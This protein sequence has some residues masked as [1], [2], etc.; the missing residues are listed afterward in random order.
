[1]LVTRGL[2][3]VLCDLA[4]LGFNARWGII[5]ADDIGAN[6][7]R[8]RIWIVA[9][10]G[11]HSNCNCKSDGSKHEKKQLLADTYSNDGRHR[12][13]TEP[14]ERNSRME[15][16]CCS[17]RQFDKRSYENVADPIEQRS[18]GRLPGRSDSQRQSESG[19]I[20]CSSS[21]HGQQRKNW[22][23]AEPN[24]GRVVNGMAARSHRLKAIGNGQ[25]PEVVRVA[26]QIL[27]K[28]L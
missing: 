19:H 13:C 14:Q 16:G 21:I 3:T 10:N 26:W 24:V 7:K 27:S 11:S 15:F 25:V 22:W 12:R 17:Q 5:G 6:H 8:K 9:R 4:K 28:D 23:S 1:M 18:Q 2:D 20:G